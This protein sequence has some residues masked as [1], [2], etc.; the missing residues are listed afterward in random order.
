MSSSA[1]ISASEYGRLAE[2]AAAWLLRLRGYRVVGRNLRVAGRELDVVARRG[3][4]LVVCE[5]KARRHAGRGRPAE[6]VD[7]RRQRRMREAA[8]VLAAADPS[9]RR[10]RFDVVTV[11]GLRIRHLRGAFF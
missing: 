5:V 9:V 8:S 10:V 7:P 1:W 11:D 2:T 6:A 3:G 4:T